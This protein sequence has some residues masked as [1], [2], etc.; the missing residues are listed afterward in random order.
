MPLEAFVQVNNND[1]LHNSKAF[2][3]KPQRFRTVKA[4]YHGHVAE[5]LAKAT[6][7]RR[8][9]AQVTGEG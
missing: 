8:L 6:Q 9:D 1:W 7:G 2:D 4:D 5:L 3:G